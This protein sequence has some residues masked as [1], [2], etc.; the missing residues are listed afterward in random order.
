MFVL[1]EMMIGL[2]FAGIAPPE[3][4]INLVDF[5]QVVKYTGDAPRNMDIEKLERGADGWEA[6]KGSSDEYMIGVE[7]AQPRDIAEAHIEFRHAI[8]DRHEIKVQYFQ[9]EIRGAE[10]GGCALPDPYHGQ[11]VT[12]EVKW[13]A[14]DREVIFEFMEERESG[15]WQRQRV[16]YRTCRLRF[17]CGRQ[18]RPPVR[19]LRAYGSRQVREATLEL[20][21]A[22]GSEL[23]VPVKVSACNGY[24]LNEQS[25]IIKESKVF[26]SLPA[27][28]K[29]RYAQGDRASA[30]QTIVTVR[31]LYEPGSGFSFAPAEVVCRGIVRIPTAGVVVFHKGSEKDLQA[32]YR[33]GQSVYDSIENA[34]DSSWRGAADCVRKIAQTQP[35]GMQAK[36]EVH[37]A[38][39]GKSAHTAKLDVPCV[40]LNSLWSRQ[41]KRAVDSEKEGLAKKRSLEVRCWEIMGLHE[42]A[43][44]YLEKLIAKQSQWEV[45]GRVRINH[46]ALGETLMD[47]VLALD[48]LYA[49]YRFTNDRQW[50]LE[51][52]HVLEA[53]CEFLIELV[54]DGGKDTEDK[55]SLWGEGLLPAGPVQEGGAWLQWYAVNAY[56]WKSLCEAALIL[57]EVGHPQAER[58]ASETMIFGHVLRQSC[59]SAMEQAP[60]VRWRDG[61][62]GSVQPLY[63]RAKVTNAKCIVGGLCGAIQLVHDGIYADESNEAEWILRFCEEQ[64]FEGRVAGTQTAGNLSSQPAWEGS[65][66]AC[67]LWPTVRIYLERGQRDHALH[68]FYQS[69][70]GYHKRMMF[71]EESE[72]SAGSVLGDQEEKNRRG[73]DMEN[74]I[75]ESAFALCLRD[76]LIR[77]SDKELV[78]LSG[79]PGSWLEARRA[80]RFKNAPTHF[81]RVNMEVSMDAV[82]SR[83]GVR[84][85]RFSTGK[86][87]KRIR[88]DFPRLIKG[89][90][91]EGG[92]EVEPT[93]EGRAICL[94]GQ[95][96]EC[97]MTVLY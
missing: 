93:V 91:V 19:Y 75:M 51:R 31:E 80:I 96:E 7:W 89:V 74:S 42:Q 43:E 67:V 84:F 20:R 1:A 56:A 70:A 87:P 71:T 58:I 26:E 69:L 9:H 66:P 79:V 72:G 59:R 27:A 82:R 50:L 4:R 17:I 29:V 14:G 81:G 73:K 78:L 16:A 32:G 25:G 68:D 45:K 76:M 3:N 28:L 41:L 10:Q 2:M 37:S 57:E 83:I 30:S 44:A 8:A 39:T 62:Y 23:Q 60:V 46:G 52:A 53:A 86:D 88:I 97:R 49:H 85:E 47:H 54:K 12:P 64:W 33:L 38:D 36:R 21:L 65:V 24:L 34:R 35:G 6:W 90:T 48:L 22:R 92:G 18:E 55:A 5:G 95:V 63:S 11:W 15:T 61:N 13:C 94:P 77:E 40:A